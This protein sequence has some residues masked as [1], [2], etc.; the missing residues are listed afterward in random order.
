MPMAV[1]L[2]L[3]NGIYRLLFGAGTTE[4]QVDNRGD[5]AIRKQLH[6]RGSFGRPIK[7]S[8]RSIKKELFFSNGL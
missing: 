1:D 2:R 8:L 5:G 4:A 3:I 6:C 7:T